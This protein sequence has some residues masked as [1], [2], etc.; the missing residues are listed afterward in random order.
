MSRES[1]VLF[2]E[3]FPF[4]GF[5]TLGMLWKASIRKP[6]KCLFSLAVLNHILLEQ[7]MAKPINL[8]PEIAKNVTITFNLVLSFLTCCGCFLPRH[9]SF[10]PGFPVKCERTWFI[11]WTN[12]N[13]QKGKAPL[14]IITR[15]NCMLK[16]KVTPET[17]YVLKKKKTSP[18]YPTAGLV[19]QF[20]VTDNSKWRRA[21]L[22][23][24]PLWRGISVG[25]DAL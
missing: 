22:N 18:R 10:L 8:P 6:S 25:S 16:E 5:C 2:S 1:T 13:R 9:L 4:P 17:V 12:Y 3:A 19:A 20:D 24:D 23:F 21:V 14:S 7:A 15:S 11:H